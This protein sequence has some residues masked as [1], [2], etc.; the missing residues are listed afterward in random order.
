MTSKHRPPLAISFIWNIADTAAVDPIINV[1]RKNFARD[2]DKPFS[3]GLNIP[4]FYFSSQNPSEAPNDYPC[5]IAR[6]NLT[7]I[8]T[9]A[10][11][12][13]IEAWKKYVEEIPKSSSTNVIPIA[14]D[15][16]G[17]GH[18]GELKGK[19]CI[20]TYDWPAENKD[21]R[22][23]V[24]LA[25]E[26]YRYGFVSINPEEASKSSSITI[27]LSHAKAGDTGRL[28]AEEIKKF[29]DNTNMNRFFDATDISAAFAFDQEL[30]KN[31]QRS[32]LVA[33][34][35]DAYSSRYWCQREI[36]CAKQHDRPI[37]VV[38]S[39]SEYEDRIFP[40]ASNVPCIHVSPD[41]PIS[42]RDILRVLS[43]AILETVR[44]CHALQCL[45]FYKDIGWID[46]ECVLSARP[47]EI[48]QALNMRKAEKKKI[49]YPE[50]PIY[51]DEA[52]WHSQL[53]LDAFTPLWHMNERDSLIQHRIGIS[54]SEVHGDGFL[55]NHIHMDHLTRLAQDLAR[56]LLAR[57]ATLIYGG[58][59][60]A[61]GFTEFI[62]DEAAILKDRL[63]KDI[64]KV[65]NHLAWPLYVTDPATIQWQARFSQVMKTLKHDIPTDVASSI[66]TDVF[67]P[68]N[69]P[70]NAYI[71][72][73]CLS[74]MRAQSI[75]Q[76]T[77]R[78]CAGGKLFEYKGKMP[79]VLE[80]V[81]LSLHSQK[82]IFLLGAFGGVVSHICNMLEDKH[83]PEVFTEEWQILHTSGYSDVQNIAKAHGH[84][85]DYETITELI[86]SQNLSTL[87]N[88]CGLL[89]AEYLTI[90]RSP[91]IDECLHLILKGL[92]ALNKPH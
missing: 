12:L 2:K 36:L 78:I 54:I 24:S 7:F 73:R 58:D 1:I 83:S 79:G 25:H 89:E 77:S 50:P 70:N 57:S 30:D 64:P 84:Q 76:S 66:S 29:I 27:F 71:W 49:C 81:A 67:L 28:H 38:N 21:L 13:G 55:N 60:R 10:N 3:R 62:L 85:C 17:L 68:P 16:C 4:L 59:L 9:S 19:N 87:A 86:N 88:R 56:H 6:K 75:V 69:T 82:P 8:F 37:L 14:L 32:T 42:Q 44:H 61:D 90:M 39:L 51:F 40:A 41:T 45:D 5:G 47:P 26:I 92:N 74:E 15:H 80:E 34:E 52:D 63:N 53:D 18:T 46:S 31:V 20:R 48:R 33:I 23:I 22:I 91:F 35:S 11:T 72:S 43:G 65:E